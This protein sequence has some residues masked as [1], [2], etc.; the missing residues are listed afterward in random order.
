MTFRDVYEVNGQEVRDRDA[1]LEELF[2]NPDRST[3]ER[4]EAI[5]QESARFNL[6]P[7]YRD[8]NVPTLALVMLHPQHQGRFRWERKGTREFFGRTAIELR[9]VETESPSLVR[10]LDG[11]DVTAEVRFWIEEETGRVLRTEASYR[12]VRRKGRPSARCWINTQ[13]R[14][15]STLALWVPE[16]MYERYEHER[17]GHVEARARYTNLRRFQVE[18]SE[19]GARLGGGGLATLERWCRRWESNPHGA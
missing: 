13:Y 15:E 2:M 3:L 1:R 17:R 16:E 19:E 6:G 10:E 14:P 4:A 11:S 9:G 7:T 5:R 12:L 18:T 8:V